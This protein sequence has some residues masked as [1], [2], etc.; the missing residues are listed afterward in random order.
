[1]F[2][3]YLVAFLV[4]C[5]LFLW[6]F[7]G[8]GPGRPDRPKETEAVETVELVP[9]PEASRPDEET[10]EVAEEPQQ[11]PVAYA[12][13]QSVD[14]PSS[15]PV[16]SSAFYQQLAIP[17]PTE[18]VA[19]GMVIPKAHYTRPAAVR[20]QAA[21]PVFVDKSMLDSPPRTRM[22]VDPVYPMDL[23]IAG[24]TGS[25]VVEVSI[26]MDGSIS[27]VKV[28]RAT[29]VRFEQAVMAVI[30]KWRFEPG[31]IGGKRV[32]FRTTLPFDFSI[33]E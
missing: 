10:I 33:R 18:A 3:D 30:R 5:G 15:L 4:S 21:T 23:Q 20:A 9:L 11:E 13:P 6:L 1:M 16:S 29:N 12:P 8:T 27:A 7:L 14:I 28:V 32:R 22:R 24:V 17:P 26:E 25:V 2:R 31:K 19:G